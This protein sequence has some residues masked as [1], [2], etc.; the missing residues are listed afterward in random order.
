MFRPVPL[1]VAGQQAFVRSFMDERA[2][3]GGPSAV[4]NVVSASVDART[5]RLTADVTGD[6]AALRQAAHRRFGTT[7]ALRPGKPLELYSRYYDGGSWTSGNALWDEQYESRAVGDANCTQGFNWRRWSD[8]VRY[9]STAGHCFNPGDNVFNGST[10]QRMGYVGTKYLNNGEYV[11]FE[12]IRIT[13]GSVDNSVWV[14]G[15]PNAQERRVVTADNDGTQVDFQVCSSGANY[16]L[17]CGT[18]VNRTAS[19]NYGA[20]YG[21]VTL[22][23]LTC[24]S[25]LAGRGFPGPGDSVAPC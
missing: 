17:A 11:D 20:R 3:W 1:S 8:N 15:T 2:S 12:Y 24:V 5:G 19:F 25:A 9:A 14:G 10:T 4:R 18:I 21:Y 6:L 23:N 22:H 13:S 16:G 7:V